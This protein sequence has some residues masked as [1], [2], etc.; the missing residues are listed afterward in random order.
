MDHNIHNIEFNEQFTRAFEAMDNGIKN[1]FITGKAGTGKS[2]LL[3]HFR[4]NTNKK[5]AVLASTGAAAV[6][7]K[8]QTIHSFFGFKPDVTLESIRLVGP[9]KRAI[10]KSID[11]IIIDEVSMVRADL[12]DCIDQFLRFNGKDS[13][14]PFGGVQAIFIGD[15]YQLSPVVKNNE[16]EI[17][18]SHYETPYF[19]SA[20]CFK[21]LKVEFVELKVIYRQS[22]PKFI[23]SL[24]L[25][26]N[27]S[28]N[29]TE[30]D[31]INERYNA[32]FNPKANDFY[33]YLTTTNASAELINAKQLTEMHTEELEFQGKIDG[34]FGKE[35][36]PTLIDLKLKLDSQVMILRNDPAGRFINGTIGKIVGVEESAEPKLVIQLETGKR[37][38]IAPHKWELYNFYMEDTELKS[39]IIGT[40][41]QYPVT[42][43]WAITV[44][45]SQGKTFDKVILDIGSGTFAHGQVYVALSR[46]RTLEGLVLKKKITK[47]HII[48]DSAIPKFMSSYTKSTSGVKDKLWLIEE[49]IAKQCSINITYLRTN[50]EKVDKIIRPTGVKEMSYRNELYIGI[51]AI[52]MES[53]QSMLFRLDGIL[54]IENIGE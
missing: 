47:R 23:Q 42:L 20:H 49:A 17:F 24:N 35:Q 12:F 27:N 54:K 33:I 52:C 51:K 41:T 38:R 40:F 29:D 43:A 5:V 46:C 50:G 8:G 16:R 34:D 18:R 10:Y 22:D 26:R 11:V 1:L 39:K 3:N 28:I 36:L 44:H 37:V 14:K 7:I 32:S 30:L 21:E 45:K 48:M 13:S 53:Q 9:K 19:F 15:L 2:T 4:K 6:N 25:I 31:V